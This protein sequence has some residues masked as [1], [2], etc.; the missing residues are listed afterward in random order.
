MST[1][2]KIMIRPAKRNDAD[3]LRRLAERDSTPLDSDTYLI[4]EVGGSPRAAIGRRRGT[5]IA[6]PFEPTADL[7]AMLELAQPWQG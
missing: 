7:V 3:A 4:A 5:V 6:D 2:T 1:A